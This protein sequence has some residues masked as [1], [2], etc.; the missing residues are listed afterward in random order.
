M[1]AWLLGEL[2]GTPYSFDTGIAIILGFG[3]WP[4]GR[5]Y[6]IVR[7]VDEHGAPMTCP[8]S[9]CGTK[10]PTCPICKRIEALDGTYIAA[11]PRVTKLSP[12]SADF[13]RRECFPQLPAQVEGWTA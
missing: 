1:K 2:V 6:A 10:S 12:E 8:D 13:L 3:E 4:T 11:E 9:R 5:R 7:P